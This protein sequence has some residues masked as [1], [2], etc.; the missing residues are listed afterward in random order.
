MISIAKNTFG[1]TVQ[2]R[3]VETYPIQKDARIWYVEDESTFVK[4][5]NLV[6]LTVWVSGFGL[7][8]PYYINIAL[9]LLVCKEGW[10]RRKRVWEPYLIGKKGGIWVNSWFNNSKGDYKMVTVSYTNF[11]EWMIVTSCSTSPVN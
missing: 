8:F 9:C 10:G 7:T 4:L 1:H 3:F 2:S 6:A 5:S 11:I